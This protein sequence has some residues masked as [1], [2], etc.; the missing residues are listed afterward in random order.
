[1]V[2]PKSALLS[3]SEFSLL[4]LTIFFFELVAT[5]QFY[6]HLSLNYSFVPHL[7]LYVLF[8]YFLCKLSGLFLLK[9][10]M[11]T[12]LIVFLFFM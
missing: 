7:C 6:K 1:L 4:S 12:K 3:P 5:L 10:L 9:S 11:F 2:S 8:F